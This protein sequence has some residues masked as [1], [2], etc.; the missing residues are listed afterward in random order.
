MELLDYWRRAKDHLDR[1]FAL[2][3]PEWVD[4]ASTV[5]LD[6]VR[7]SIAAGKKSRGCLVCLSCEALGGELGAAIP[8]AVAVECIHTASLIHDDYVDGDRM[9]RNHPAIWTIEGSRSAVLLADIM[10]ATAI[11]KMVQV[12][13]R[14]AEIL[15]SAIA[16][17][18]KGAYREY[19]LAADGSSASLESEEHAKL[20]EH[21]I[22]LK[23][24]TLFAA[25][26]QLGALAACD[27]PQLSKRAFSFGMLMGEAY[28]I[29]DDL[30]EIRDLRLN[31]LDEPARIIPLFPAIRYFAGTH[32]QALLAICRQTPNEVTR[33]GNHL[34][35]DI[36]SAMQ[37]EITARSNMA[38]RELEDFPSG[39]YARLLRELPHFT[40][41]LLLEPHAVE[42][43]PTTLDSITF[44]QS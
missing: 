43:K 41:R 22:R 2:W 15:A 14:D 37:C 5:R 13:R 42:C 38:E 28:Q 19:R 20:Y 36:E 30:T 17:M 40:I 12:G 3:I 9:R 29:A 16:T 31:G 24:G 34:L 1:E 23:T 39:P 18:A 10:F 4:H 21:I 32:A 44:E 11:R 7:R 6:T 27:D 35:Q 25:A 8:Q 26:A 33:A